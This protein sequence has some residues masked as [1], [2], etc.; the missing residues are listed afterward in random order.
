[1]YINTQTK[2]IYARI[3]QHLYIQLS[4]PLKGLFMFI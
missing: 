2:K 4:E 1:M 3:R